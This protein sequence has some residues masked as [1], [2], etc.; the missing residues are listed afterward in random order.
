MVRIT[1]YLR[2]EPVEAIDLAEARDRELVQGISRRD[3][4][5]FRGLFGR[6]AP[7]ATSLAMR[8]VRQSH[9]AEEIVQ[10]AFMALWRNPAAYDDTRGS[11]KSWL[12]GM[13]HH[14]AVDMVRREESHRRRAEKTAH[15][16]MELDSDHADEVVEQIG[17]PEERR[18]VRAALD[19]LP[20]AQREV[21]ERMYFDGMSQSQ[22]AEATG[23]P[24][25]TVKSRTL[26]GMRR[27]RAVLVQEEP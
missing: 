16:A 27:L 13:V 4:E 12:V 6:Y 24:L 14:R 2:S 22:I 5:A 18:R 20:E 17:L 3:E 11:V 25:G 19:E 7:S 23:L 21:L 15:Q 8:V 26:L 10:E 1:T 9:L